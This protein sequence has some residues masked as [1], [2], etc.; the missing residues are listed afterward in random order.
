MIGHLLL[1]VS[2]RILLLLELPRCHLL[3]SAIL[4]CT[5]VSHLPTPPH[6]TPPQPQRRQRSQQQWNPHAHSHARHL[7]IRVPRIGGAPR[8]AARGER[9]GRRA[10]DARRG[11]DDLG[12]VGRGPA[13]EL[14]RPRHAERVRC[15]GEGVDALV[16]VG[17]GE[18]ACKRASCEAQ[19]AEAQRCAFCGEFY[20]VAVG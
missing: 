10:R 7:A 11:R 1:E 13:G 8:R 20:A 9:Q 3:R 2:M 19:V 5:H 18:A 6:L 15:H 17:Q 14:R 4:P 16:A 12:A